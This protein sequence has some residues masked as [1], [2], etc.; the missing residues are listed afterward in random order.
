MVNVYEN[1]LPTPLNT[2]IDRDVHII[3]PQVRF[4]VCLQLCQR[5]LA[6][7]VHS[8]FLEALLHV[9]AEIPAPVDEIPS[10]RGSFEGLCLNLRVHKSLNS[11]I[12]HAAKL[13][14][15]P[16][17]FH[18][19]CANTN[20][21]A[22][23]ATRPDLSGF[24][25]HSISRVIAEHTAIGKGEGRVRHL[26]LV[27]VERCCGSCPGCL[28]HLVLVLRFIRLV[29]AKKLEGRVGAVHR[30]NKALKQ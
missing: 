29:A 4:C 14:F 28:P 22:D 27:E 7:I 15:E 9:E 6:R 10:I 26:H 17:C 1:G 8:C 2:L 18:D 19:S 20:N 25:V 23:I 12:D 30:T 11:E 3:R 21:D 24:V 16:G 13:I 5:F